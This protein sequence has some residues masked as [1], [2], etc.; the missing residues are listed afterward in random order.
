MSILGHL[1]IGIFNGINFVIDAHGGVSRLDP[2]GP[3]GLGTHKAVWDVLRKWVAEPSA[4]RAFL[5]MVKVG[6]TTL[7]DCL[8]AIWPGAITPA[9]AGKLIAGWGLDLQR[10]KD[11]HKFRNISS[12]NPQAL[13]PMPDDANGRL[14][15]VEHIWILFEPTS[16]SR[17]DMLDRHLLRA[18]LWEQHLIVNQHNGAGPPP[19]YAGGSI[20]ARYDELPAS[21][22]QIAS[23]DFL[24]AQLEPD[25]PELIQCARSIASPAMAE[26]MLARALLL[27]RAATAFTITNFADAGIAGG[28]GKLRRWIDPVAVARGFWAPTAALADPADLWEDVRVALED[29][30]DSKRT[31]PTSLNDWITKQRNGFPHIS[32]AERIGVW[33]LAL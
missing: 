6:N 30:A 22:R 3:N 7:E 14:N 11:D 10:G 19:P 12:Y 27:L 13:A 26:H 1:G 32:E 2:G 5:R 18:M 16:A 15:F 23:K 33:S 20:A 29:L 31:A 4:A 21:V 25:E 17:F 24:T 9:V 28:S 8:D